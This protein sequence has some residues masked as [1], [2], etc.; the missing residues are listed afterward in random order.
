MEDYKT[1]MDELARL[2]TQ[3][4]KILKGMYEIEKKLDKIKAEKAATLYKEIRSK[5]NELENLGYYFEVQVWNNDCGDYDWYN[6]TDNAA[7]RYRY[8]DEVI[9][10]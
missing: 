3:K 5:M 2:N 6:A 4:Q 1:L 7:F 9:V 8:K 10:D